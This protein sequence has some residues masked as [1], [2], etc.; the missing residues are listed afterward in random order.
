[1]D[2][3]PHPIATAPPASHSRVWGTLVVR[4]TRADRRRAVCDA[5]TA[6]AIESATSQWLYVPAKKFVPPKMAQDSGSRRARCVL[7][8]GIGGAKALRLADLGPF[9]TIGSVA[10]RLEA[11]IGVPVTESAFSRRQMFGQLIKSK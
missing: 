8:S 1:M 10:P 5:K 4:A 2:Q 9:Q 6:T 11:W 7:T 3:I